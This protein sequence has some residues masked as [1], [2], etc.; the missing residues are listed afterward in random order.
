MK[1]TKVKKNL[2]LSPKFAQK[3]ELASVYSKKSQS[4]IVEEMLDGYIDVDIKNLKMR[5]L[6]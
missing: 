6:K 3:L 4:K 1:M 5:N 2:T